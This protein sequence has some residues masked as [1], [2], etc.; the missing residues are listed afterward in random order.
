MFGLTEFNVLK[1]RKGYYLALVTGKKNTV[2]SKGVRRYGTKSRAYDAGV[3]LWG[4]LKK[5]EK[6]NLLP[7]RMGWKDDP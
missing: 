2:V 3:M 1:D 6:E 4:K 7:V 5:N